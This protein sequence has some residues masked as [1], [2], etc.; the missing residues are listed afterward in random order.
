MKQQSITKNLS[1]EDWRD[2][3]VNADSVIENESRR[4]VELDNIGTLVPSTKNMFKDIFTEYLRDAHENDLEVKIFTIYGIQLKAKII[5]FDAWVVKISFEDKNK[6]IKGTQ[7]VNR[8]AIATIGLV[9]A[10]DNYG[11]RKQEDE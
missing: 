7:I 11:N 6:K 1:Y 5:D 2:L 8:S 9:S 3:Q 10:D 4:M